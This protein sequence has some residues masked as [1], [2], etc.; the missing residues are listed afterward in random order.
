VTNDTAFLEQKEGQQRNVILSTT[1][2]GRPLVHEMLFS[3]LGFRK[4]TF[5]QAAP[6]LGATWYPSAT[7]L[8]P[9]TYCFVASIRGEP[10]KLLDATDG[11]VRN[12][13]HGYVRID[14]EVSAQMR[15]YGHP[16]K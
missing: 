2:V 13:S 6:I 7:P 4:S 15:S 10:V 12:R 11:R 3:H 5:K 9:E 8:R 1:R 14:P 16:T